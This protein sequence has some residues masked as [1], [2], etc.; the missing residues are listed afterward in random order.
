MRAARR[1]CAGYDILEVHRPMVCGRAGAESRPAS[2]ESVRR[3]CR[4]SG[5]SASFRVRA[6]S[7]LRLTTPGVANDRLC[8]GR[9]LRPTILRRLD[10]H[11]SLEQA[12]HAVLGISQASLHAE[13]RLFFYAL[14]A[15]LMVSTSPI[16]MRPSNGRASGRN[17][18]IQQGGRSEDFRSRPEYCRRD[19]GRS[20]P[21]R[22][23][24]RPARGRVLRHPAP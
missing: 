3:P 19:P 8:P 9:T 4:E 16:A 11:G 1:L 24:P 22:R 2:R 7:P 15:C 21:S 13:G 6:A 12:P 18:F 5:E 14:R 10:A 17:A 20:R 23:R